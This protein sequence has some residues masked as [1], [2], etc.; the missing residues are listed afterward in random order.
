MNDEI[1]K[2]KEYWNNI[3]KN[4]N[5][6]DVIYD[7]WLDSFH[8]IIHNCQTPILDLGCGSGNNTLYLIE[9]GKKVIACDI[10]ENA[11]D[12]IKKNFPEI[13]N[14]KCFNMLEGMPFQD[15]TFELIV[16]DLSLHYF[17]D[18]DTRHIINELQRILKGNGYLIIRVNSLNDKNH[19]AGEG[20]EIEDHLYK[21]SDGRLK[22]FF[23]EKD[24]IKYFHNFQIDYLKE[25][26]MA[27][28][29]LPKKLY[30]VCLR[31]HK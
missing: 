21:T 25:E 4:Y 31:N 1:E 15:N 26:T 6:E 23:D 13:E 28:Y 11:I 14:A 16:A 20:I 12:N 30:K 3:H 8:S 22:R 10:S 19:G 7:N 24:I 5:R 9:K 18:K 2:S 17:K 27:R 29:K